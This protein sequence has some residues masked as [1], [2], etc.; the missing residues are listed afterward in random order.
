MGL[1]A[2]Q[3]VFAATIYSN[4]VKAVIL[5]LVLV[6]ETYI[7]HVYNINMYIS[8]NYL[9][10]N[11]TSTYIYTTFYFI[12]LCTVSYNVLL[13]LMTHKSTQTSRRQ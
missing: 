3:S 11:N 12:I 8:F 9:K 1:H 6:R 2:F 7:Y 5:S 13:I 10:K 4:Q